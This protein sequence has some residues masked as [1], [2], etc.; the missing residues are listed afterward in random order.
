MKNTVLKNIKVMT[1]MLAF[2]AALGFSFEMS[3]TSNRQERRLV[4]KGNKLFRGG[5]YLEAGEVYQQALKVEPGSKEA[6]YNLGL[7]YIIIQE[8]KRIAEA[9]CNVK[10]GVND[11]RKII[12][13]LY[14]DFVSEIGTLLKNTD[15]Q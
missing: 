6:L 13:Q 11:T 3:A 8:P 2:V 5:N 4:D 9:I 10:L 15:L 12:G 14:N 1:L 7:T